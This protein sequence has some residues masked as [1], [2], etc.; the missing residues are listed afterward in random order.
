MFVTLFCRFRPIVGMHHG[1]SSLDYQRIT[2]DTP[3]C[4]PTIRGILMAIFKTST[5]ACDPIKC[6][7]NYRSRDLAKGL[8][9]NS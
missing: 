8:I 4:V 3:W 6:D 1:A 2:E 7:F 5:D 9:L